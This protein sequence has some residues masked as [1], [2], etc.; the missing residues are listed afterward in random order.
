MNCAQSLSSRLRDWGMPLCMPA[1]RRMSLLRSLANITLCVGQLLGH[2]VKSVTYKRI[3]WITW[4]FDY[5][6]T[7]EENKNLLLG[8]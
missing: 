8:Y 5:V 6:V 1:T 7:W 3:T 4:L 2:L